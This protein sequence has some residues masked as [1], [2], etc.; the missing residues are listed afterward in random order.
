[1]PDANLG[2]DGFTWILLGVFVLA[3]LALRSIW[4][5]RTHAPR[6]KMIWSAVALVP[7][8]GP[9]AWFVLGKQKRQRG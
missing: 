6:V 2:F 3:A 9:L 5:S 7:V 1:M 4:I 8:V